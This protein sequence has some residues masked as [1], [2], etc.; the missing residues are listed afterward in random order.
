MTQRYVS[1]IKSL[2]KIKDRKYGESILMIM[3]SKKNG[4]KD[5]GKYY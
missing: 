5:I 3:D 2:K 4:N 1:E